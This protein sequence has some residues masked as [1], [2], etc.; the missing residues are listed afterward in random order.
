MLFDTGLST[1]SAI[2]LAVMAGIFITFPL[3]SS[4][5]FPARNPDFPGPRMRWAY[6][7]LCAVLFVLMMGTVVVFGKEDEEAKA[8]ET[9]QS[10][11]GETS[12]TE[13]TPSPTTPSTGE[14]LPAK[15]ANGDAA[16]GAEI[17]TSKGCGACHTMEAA[18]ATGSVGPNLDEAK[19]SEALIADRVVHGKGAMPPFGPQLTDKQIADVVAYVHESTQSSS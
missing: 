14:G 5:V 1:T 4:F 18:G 13:T 10:N 17:F 8:Q 12:S 7:G 2:A 11:P 3:L 16:A 6:V 19:P 15:Y 9:A